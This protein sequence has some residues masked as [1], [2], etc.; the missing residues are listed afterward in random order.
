ML[1]VPIHPADINTI[2]GSY[3]IKPSLPHVPGYDGVAE[4]LEVGSE[5]QGLQSG[6][7]VI[8]RI[9]S[10]GTCRTHMRASPENLI[11]IP[12]DMDKVSAATFALN[13]GT[14]Y[15]MLHDFKSLREGDV[16]IQNGANSAVGQAVIQI[17]AAMG[18]QT[19]NIVRDRPEINELKQYLSSLGATLVLTE[20]E[21]RSSTAIKEM[22]QPILALNCVSGRSGTEILRRLAFGGVMVTYGGMSRQPVTVPIGSLIFNEVSVRGFWMSR[23]NTKHSD[24]PERQHMLDELHKL[25]IQ[26]KLKPPS[27]SLVPFEQFKKVFE[28][29]LSAEG[30]VGKKQILVFD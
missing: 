8:P 5:V 20:E 15:R 18:L 4:V 24:K 22:T 13:P 3:G 21:V 28:N 29:T 25:V 12:S 9:L 27:H 14:A 26:K 10:S 17:A 19:I 1:A 23:W 7:W 11:K 16:V 2:Q 30:K 6:D